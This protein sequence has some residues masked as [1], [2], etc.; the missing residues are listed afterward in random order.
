MTYYAFLYRN[1]TDKQPWPVIWSNRELAEKEPFRV[2]DI[3]EVRMEEYLTVGREDA[4][5]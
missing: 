2:S 4:L 5:R 3:V 1:K